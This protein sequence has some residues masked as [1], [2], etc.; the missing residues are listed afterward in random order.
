[1]NHIQLTPRQIGLLA[2]IT[3]LVLAL[4]IGAVWYKHHEALVS[5]HELE[6]AKVINEAQAANVQDLKNV[7]QNQMA[8][9]QQN[10]EMTAQA[11]QAARSGQTQPVTHFTVTA[12]TVQAA[13][14][15]VSKRIDA[16]D[17][18]LPPAAIAASDRTA[19]IPNTQQ[20]KVDVFKINN[21]RNWEWSA[22]V[23]VHGGDR[24][25]PVELQRNFSKDAAMA[26]EYH[27][28]GN[29]KGWE[30]KYIRKTDKLFFLF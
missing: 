10:S 17:P 26:L 7:L 30:L 21:Y 16:K 14:Q 19:V 2:G 11:I 25:I 8:M 6:K 22:G 18:T 27:V 9:N 23:G 3:F 1:M 20:Q 12:P 29:E 15:D 4:L 5:Q 28:G 24:Y 13:A